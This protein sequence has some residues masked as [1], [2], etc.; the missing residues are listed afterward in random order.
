MINKYINPQ[1]TF[2]EDSNLKYLIGNRKTGIAPSFIRLRLRVN[3]CE[4][5]N[6]ESFE[7]TFTAS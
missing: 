5:I 7:I 3:L 6:G 2:I 1:V 4:S